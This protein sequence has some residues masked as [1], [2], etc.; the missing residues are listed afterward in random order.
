MDDWFVGERFARVMVMCRGRRGVVV[1]CAFLVGGL[2][3]GD[4]RSRWGVGDAMLQQ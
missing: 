2:G 4:V 3:L 1:G